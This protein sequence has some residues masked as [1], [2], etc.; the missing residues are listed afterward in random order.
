MYYIKYLSIIFFVI[1]SKLL[2]AG[3][4]DT[5]ANK[6]TISGTIIDK[7][8]GEKLAGATI[9]I[10]EINNGTLSNAYGFYSITLPK[11]NY[12]LI[13]RYVG[14][15]DV[16][17]SVV[18]DKNLKINIDLISSAKN[19]D[20]VEITAKAK[21]E[22]VRSTEMGVV[23]MD[24]QTIKKIPAFMG[25]IDILKTIQLLPGVISTGE[26]STGY[27]V[28]GGGTDQNL[29][30]MDEAQIFNASHLM[31]F[32]SIFNNDAVKDLK[33]YKGDMPAAY[34]GRLSS[35]L[36]VHQK[37]G[38]NKNYGVTG[39]L[40]LISSRLLIEGPLVKSKSSFLI[41][42]RRSY[43]D[44]FLPLA[45]NKDLRNNKLYFYDFNFKVNADINDK[46]RIYASGYFG[47]DVIKMANGVNFGLDWG[48]NTATVRWN[49]LFSNKLFSNFTLLRSD[50]NYS[51]GGNSQSQSFTWI[52]RM[53]NY[54]LKNDYGYFLNPDNT[55][56]FGIFT[57]YHQFY[58]GL[59]TATTE[60]MPV[61]KLKF[62]IRKDLNTE[63]TYKTNK[64][65]EAY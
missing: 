49:H 3:G 4:V 16:N 2:Q 63:D 61:M 60:A 55:I 52:S 30:L 8:N 13:Y 50:Y 12:T 18:L 15:L 47:R 37:E 33:L 1:C 39:G 41:A 42:G 6:L 11:G 64:N 46:N 14:Y 23:K 56:K 20:E 65:L 26:G 45:P 53:T 28:R 35:L 43:A 44:I 38:N 5:E 36:D 24:I 51:L 7:A 62:L 54:S 25:E 40:G 34:G 32:F 22:N 59:I 27:S 29:I 58:P 31:G 9:Y 21:N 17:R 48:N 10:P 57:S 19:L